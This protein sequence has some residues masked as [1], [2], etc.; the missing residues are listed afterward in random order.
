[1][2]TFEDSLPLAKEKMLDNTLQPTIEQNTIVCQMKQRRFQ[3]TPVVI[4]GRFLHPVGI[5]EGAAGGAVTC[6][7]KGKNAYGC[8]RKNSL[9]AVEPKWRETTD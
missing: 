9:P 7:P 1:M 5:A 8:H 3:M 4:S 2:A 6:G